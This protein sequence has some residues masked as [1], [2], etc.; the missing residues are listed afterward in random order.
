MKTIK[1]IFK[2]IAG[3]II[4]MGVM[5]IAM[6]F[7]FM[8]PFL[9]IKYT[10]SPEMT[11]GM[12]DEIIKEN[13]KD[14]YD[15][16]QRLGKNRVPPKQD[17]SAF[18]SYI[19]RLERDTARYITEGKLNSLHI[20]WYHGNKEADEVKYIVEYEAR[21]AWE[22]TK[23]NAG[24]LSDKTTYYFLLDRNLYILGMDE[25]KIRE[26]EICGDNSFFINYLLMYGPIISSID[27]TPDTILHPCVY[28]LCFRS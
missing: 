9:Y 8:Y 28:N 26:I 24:N 17:D 6:P 13:P 2:W 7:A 10:L 1:N 5:C 23:A 18:Q 19:G 14:I 4:I 15:I 25:R 16:E 20:N 27:F 12:M 22:R 21:T 3:I 11:P